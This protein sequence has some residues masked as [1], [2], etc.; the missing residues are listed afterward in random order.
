LV[1]GAPSL[2]SLVTVTRKV[3]RQVIRR[4]Q[5]AVKGQALSIEEFFTR[6]ARYKWR[7]LIAAALF[8]FAG[9]ALAAWSVFG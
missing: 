4:A 7:L 2:V 9:I 6:S 1:A 3:D 8:C 5:P